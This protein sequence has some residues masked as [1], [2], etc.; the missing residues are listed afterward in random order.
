[1][2][3]TQHPF[4]LNVTARRQTAIAEALLGTLIRIDISKATAQPCSDLTFSP[5]SSAESASGNT[6]NTIHHVTPF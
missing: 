1:M 6:D 4:L 3:I 5:F 2:N